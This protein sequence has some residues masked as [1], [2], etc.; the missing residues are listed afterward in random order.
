MRMVG[1]VHAR[2]QM[3]EKMRQEEITSSKAPRVMPFELG[4]YLDC[5]P[6]IN[7]FLQLVLLSENFGLCT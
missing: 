1:V 7:T 4:D 6:L 5:G 2:R 3:L